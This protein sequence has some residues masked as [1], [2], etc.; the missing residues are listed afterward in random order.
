MGQQL[1][2]APPFAGTTSASSLLAIDQRS[3]SMYALAS[4]SCQIPRRGHVSTV[5]AFSR[6]SVSLYSS[7]YWRLLFVVTLVVVND[8][9]PAVL[10]AVYII[11]QI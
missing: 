4:G 11:V 6:R 3:A 9:A 7:I 10:L 2:T 1:D 5:F 8:A